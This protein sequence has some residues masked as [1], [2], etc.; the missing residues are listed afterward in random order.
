MLAGYKI[1]TITHKC[2]KLD[3]IGKFIIP[4]TQ[5]EEVK[6][7]LI[8]LKNRFQFDE[9]MYVATCNRVMFAFYSKKPL[10][11]DFLPKFFRAVNPAL[12][13]SDLMHSSEFAQIFEGEHAIRHTLS[14]AASIDSLVIGEREILRQLREG[15]D[16][17][18][19]WNLTGDN[20]RLM[21]DNVVRAAKSVYSDTGIGEKP[22]SVASLAVQQ[23]IAT[24]L[25]THAP[26]LLVGAGQTNRLVATILH[27]QGY[28]NFTVF[29]RTQEKA[30]E[31][32]YQ[33]GGRGYALAQLP[34]YQH[35]FAGMIVCTGATEAVI[36]THLYQQLLNG[37]PENKIIIDLSIP[38]NVDRQVV[39]DFNTTYI[40][41]DTLKA[42]AREN[43][44]HR[45]KEVGKAQEILDEYFDTFRI[46]YQQRQLQLAMQHVPTE[47]RAVKERAKKVFSKQLENLDEETLLLIDQ[48]LNY[49]EQKCISIPMKAAKQ[50]VN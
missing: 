34:D 21:M 12:S 1:V 32:A 13:A 31:L 20:L 10:R 2:A 17:C 36:D 49:M 14:V 8:E 38:N 26:I 3:Q 30:Q 37:D 5:R 41:I 7:R 45:E 15:Y 39:L 23:L 42:L 18:L 16:E 48:M 28:N 27:K 9:L 40:E 25:P 35:Y 4:H 33:L 46:A 11:N 43:M 6:N 44:A 50:P 29:N 47:M 19:E 24:N 22:V